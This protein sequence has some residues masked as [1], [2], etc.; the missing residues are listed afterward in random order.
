MHVMHKHRVILKIMSDSGF[1][2]RKVGM[3]VGN[4]TSED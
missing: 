4:S 2:A 1:V 3:I